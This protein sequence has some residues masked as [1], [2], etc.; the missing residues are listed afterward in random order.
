MRIPLFSLTCFFVC[1]H[2]A[3]Q[4]SCFIS[5]I[6]LLV[7]TMNSPSTTFFRL[8]STPMAPMKPPRGTTLTSMNYYP[9]SA[10]WMS[11]L[12]LIDSSHS[13]EEIAP[14][15]QLFPNPAP[16]FI[17]LTLPTPKTTIKRSLSFI[18]LTHSPP[19]K[20]QCQ[21]LL[22]PNI[23]A[24]PSTTTPKQM[25]TGSQSFPP[26]PR[27]LFLDEKLVKVE[28]P[29]SKV[30]SLSPLV[31]ASAKSFHPS[32]KLIAQLQDLSPIPSPTA[33]KMATL[34]KSDKSPEH[35]EGSEQI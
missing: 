13:P 29:I 16:R 31:S 6:H 22:E 2:I 17:D 28:P 15:I 10:S 5:Q 34:L 26:V 7:F 25:L 30:L 18:D 14:Q 1:L 20:K 8:T 33:K 12:S 19:L 9:S 23:G 35:K 24:S 3:Q 21:R 4:K 27:T 32:D 11:I